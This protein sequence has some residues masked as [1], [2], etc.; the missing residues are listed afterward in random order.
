MDDQKNQE[1]AEFDFQQAHELV[2]TRQRYQRRAKP[3][4]ELINYLL[5]RKGYGQTQSSHE[6]R[7]TWDKVVGPRWQNKTQVGN[8]RR[9]VLEVVVQN[10]GALQQLTFN[11]QKLLVSMQNQLPQ[12]KLKDIKFKVGKVN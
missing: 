4:S 2:N 11:K 9:G 12:N 10:S 3:A 5:S 7:S 1:I 8:I 6:I